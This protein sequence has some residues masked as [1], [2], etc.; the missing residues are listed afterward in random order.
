MDK[1]SFQDSIMPFA[2]GFSGPESQKGILAALDPQDK[3]S[4][5]SSKNAYSHL[6]MAIFT[7]KILSASQAN[8]FIADANM[9]EAHLFSELLKP[10]LAGA[11][12][13]LESPSPIA[14]SDPYKELS[15]YQANWILKTWFDLASPVLKKGDLLYPPTFFLSFLSDKF[16]QDRNAPGVLIYEGL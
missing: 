16:P 1:V 12:A 8:D 15:D 11:H 6:A 4:T 14:L 7:L 3:N 5:F 10:D 2:S 9:Q 13:L